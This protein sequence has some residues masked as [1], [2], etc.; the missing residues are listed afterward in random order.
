MHAPESHDGTCVT[1]QGSGC[2]APFQA[3]LDEHRRDVY[4]FL[5]ATAG[6]TDADDVFQNLD[7]R[8]ARVPRLRRADNLRA[9]LLRIAHN[10]AIDAHRARGRRALPIA[11]APE[12]PVA[13]PVADGRRSSGST[14]GSCPRAA[15]RRVLSSRARDVVRG[16]RGAARLLRGG[17]AAQRARRP[18]EIETGAERMSEIETILR[19]SGRGGCRRG[20]RARRARPGDGGLLDVAYTSVDS[21]LGPLVVAAT[22]AR[23][24]AGRLHGSQLTRRCA[25]GAGQSR[26]A[27][28]A[29]GA[30]PAR[31]RAA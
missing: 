5:V 31:R 10:K 16:A 7:R 14:S 17:C 3:V 9:W 23:A 24:G 20:A 25:R 12:Q 28:R 2:E 26:V 13:A 29:R 8:P 21:P 1:F 15:H 27:A 22:P 11:E 19:R 6:P 18:E 30:G 4:R